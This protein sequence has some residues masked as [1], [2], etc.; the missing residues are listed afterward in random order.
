[1]KNLTEP[2]EALNVIT[3]EPELE[4][5]LNNTLLQSRKAGELVIDPK[6]V[7]SMFSEIA[8]KK[9]ECENEGVTPVLVVSPGI[10]QWLA[11][12]LRQRVSG[13]QVL[14]YTEIPEDQDIV[15]KNKISITK[16]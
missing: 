8:K 14:A 2:G 10:R 9:N 3:L 15:V 12:T 11:K 7:E 4:N 5:V 1:M 16:N 13:L 6:M